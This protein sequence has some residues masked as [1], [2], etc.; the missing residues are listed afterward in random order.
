MTDEELQQ[1]LATVSD[2]LDKLTKTEA[3]LAKKEK[4]RKHVL[5]LQKDALLRLKQAREK[6]DRNAE[7]QCIAMYGLLTTCENKHPLYLHFAKQRM[8]INL[9]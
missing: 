6:G 2:T 9:F 4:R 7:F 8:G 5:T 3:P 1:A